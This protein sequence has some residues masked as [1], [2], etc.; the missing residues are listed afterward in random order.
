MPG[1][2]SLRVKVLSDAHNE[3]SVCDVC[4]PGDIDGVYT[5]PVFKGAEVLTP[6]LRDFKL[7]ATDYKNDI[8]DIAW[9]KEVKN[10]K[11]QLSDLTFEVVVN[12]I[13]RAVYEQCESLLL[14]L[15]DRSVELSVI[16]ERFELYEIAVLEKQVLRLCNGFVEITNEQEGGNDW[17]KPFIQDIQN[18]RAIKRYLGAAIVFCDLQEKFGLTGDFEGAARLIK[19]VGSSFCVNGKRIIN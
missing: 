1:L 14:K 9:N 10:F 16:D 18:Y 13:W 4:R 15:K 3:L 6:M 2:E 5:F 11:K 19:V 7:L 8:F 12:E 17:V